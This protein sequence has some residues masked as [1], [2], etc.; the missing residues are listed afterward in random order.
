[1]VDYSYPIEQVNF[2]ILH[3]KRQLSPRFK[4]GFYCFS[5]IVTSIQFETDRALSH[6]QHDSSKIEK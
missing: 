5:E 6:Q 3:Q 4:R 1:M 2:V